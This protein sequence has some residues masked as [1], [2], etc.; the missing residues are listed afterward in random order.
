[1]LGYG[2]GMEA[3]VATVNSRAVG[4]TIALLAM[5]GMLAAKDDR[6]AR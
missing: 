6:R 3:G 4:V 2:S 1:V 5:F